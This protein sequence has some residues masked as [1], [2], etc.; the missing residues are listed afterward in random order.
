MNEL[1]KYEAVCRTALATPGLS[2]TFPLHLL[3][4]LHKKSVKMRQTIDDKKTVCLE[5]QFY[6]SQKKLHNRWL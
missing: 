4:F 3:E 6:A 2:I 1:I 5:H